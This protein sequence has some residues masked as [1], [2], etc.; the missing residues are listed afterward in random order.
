MPNENEQI[1]LRSDEVQ[2]IMGHIPSRII[3]YGIM[4]MF[5]V[6]ALLF[7]GSFF[8]KYPDILTAPF[9]ITTQN[10]P[11]P[12]IAKTNGHL[13]SFSV[14]DSQQVIQNQVLAI[15]QNTANTEQL[16]YLHQQ[17]KLV[18]AIDSI[19]ANCQLFP[20]TLQLGDLQ[21]DYAG[22][23]KACLD[24]ASFKELEYFPMKIGA[25][26]QKLAN[27]KQYTYLMIQQEK[28]KSQD[29]TLAKNQFFR[30]S[31]LFVKNVISKSEYEKSR[32]DL[33]QN[34]MT[35]ENTKVA[36]VSARIQQNEIQQQITESESEWAKQ[37]QLFVNNIEQSRQAL[38]S[39]IAWWY[40]TF[41]LTTPISGTVSVNKVWNLN[42]QVNSGDVVFTIIPHQKTKIVARITLPASGAGKVKSGQSVN[43]KFDNFPYQE[44]GMVRAEVK[45]LSLVP[46]DQNFMVEV[47]V[48]E[49]LITNY[50]KTLPFS[51][52]MS[53]TA[54]IVT[55]DL[56]LAARLFNPLKSLFLKAK[57]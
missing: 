10:P 40:N 54:E 15:I 4:V 36:V 51:Q 37:Q 35:Y 1:Q 52:K 29:F 43:L 28:L 45:S 31:S 41:V 6:V 48:S 25:L 12:I 39:R 32:K 27:L 30:D 16:Y 55:E 7:T 50:K 8:F 34:Q 49:P 47:F 5:V 42:Q 53:G 3:R 33:L 2:E 14:A 17:L 56:P 22:F 19:V 21:S 18:T 9:E 24:Y 13:T 26:Q 11:I 44:F 46:T 57:I 23:R 20:D 38:F